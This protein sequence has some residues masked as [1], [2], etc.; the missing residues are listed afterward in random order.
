MQQNTLLS[1]L[2]QSKQ[3]AE[4]SLKKPTKSPK[5]LPELM[6][7]IAKLMIDENKSDLARLARVNREWYMAAIP[8]L[9]EE[10]GP[11]FYQKAHMFGRSD[12]VEEDERHMMLKKLD[13]KKLE[14]HPMDWHHA[15]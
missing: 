5:L 13:K 6:V 12:D 7:R 9:Y 14:G 1:D 10:V 8:S 2:E 15:V 11:E 3:D 4:S